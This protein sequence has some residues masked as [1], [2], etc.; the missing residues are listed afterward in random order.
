MT[1][2]RVFIALRGAVQGV[3]FRPFVYRL[4]REL[5]LNGHV[6]NDA[7]GVRI[8]VEGTTDAV[9]AFRRRLLSD[10][11]PRAAIHTL[12]MTFLDPAGLG[13]FR[14]LESA[15]SGAPSA[16]VMPDLAMCA[17]CRGELFDPSNRR[18]LYPFTNCTNCGPRFSIILSLPYDRPRTSMRSFHMCA[19][20][21]REYDDPSDRRFHAQPNACPACGPS[22]KLWDE[23]GCVLGERKAALEQAANAVRDGRIVAMKGMG[24]FQLLVDARNEDAVQR[25]RRR[26]H[27]EEKP[28]ALM[29]PDLECARGFCRI[30]PG[31][32]RTLTSSESPIVL[33]DRN[34]AAGI[35]PSVAPGNPALGIMLPYT[36]LHAI[37]MHL[38]KVPVVATSGNRSDEPMCIDERDALERLGGI[39]DLFL[40]HDRPIVRHVDDSVVRWMAGRELV[41][42]RARG[43]APLPVLLPSPV[44]HPMLCL[45]AHQKSVVARVVGDQAILSQHIGDLDT[46]EARAAFQ[47][48]ADDLT[49]L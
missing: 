20:C 34:G 16:V 36:P 44:R 4:A 17:D 1:T 46:Y 5:R 15:S 37:L 32:E 3:G 8:E 7:A 12:E 35:A 11:P 30:G 9:D 39:A 49:D 29:M 47:R 18:H 13:P 33:L 27:R 10:L 28:L 23:R 6:L 31:E 43:F 40:V 45:G 41:I 25:L 48:V 14:I 42:R 26:K 2:T 19:N 38:L 24:G 22:V 21:Q